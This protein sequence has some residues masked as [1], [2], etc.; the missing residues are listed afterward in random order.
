MHWGLDFGTTNTR[1]AR[2][3]S[4][5]GAPRALSLP[6]ASRRPEGGDET[7]AASA[8][9]TMVRLREDPDLWARLSARPWLRGRVSWGSWGSIG[10]AAEEAGQAPALATSLKP[11]LA[12]SALQTVARVNG[13]AVSAREATRAFLRELL[14][15]VRELSGS[16]VDAL[17]L[18]AP[19]D[20]YEDYRAEL[21]SLCAELGVRRTRHV[22]EP[23]AAALGYGLSLSASRRVLV[24]D[25][26]GGTLD[27]AHVELD[28][29]AAERG[30]CRVLGKA[31]RALGGTDVDRWLLEDVL[32]RADVQLTL[33][34]AGGAG[35]WRRALLDEARRL[36]ES[37]YFQEEGM[38]LAPAGGPGQRDEVSYRREDLV[39][40][41]EARGLPRQLDEALDEALAAS[42]GDA[43]VE[44]ALLVGGSTLL[45]GVYAG[46]QRRFG[47]DRVRAW[48]PFEAVALGAAA[49]CAD[50]VRP[51]DFIVHDYAVRLHDA[52][53]R[54]YHEIVVPRGTRFPTP[55]DLWRRQ[56]VPVCPLGEPERV[57]KLVICEL[58]SVAGQDR[59]LGFD[60]AERA[61]RV[62]GDRLIVPLN[63]RDP[64]MGRL[65]PPQQPTDA[66]ARLDVALGV[67]ADRWLCA[68]VRDLRT[69]REL[70]RGHP[71]VRL[72]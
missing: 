14:V 61:R 44:D 19:V 28:A 70:M 13:R 40:L 54:P 4:T 59:A 66:A 41:L 45:P 25:F 8:I 65:D 12:R 39:T 43:A 71:V 55:E 62:E 15:Q 20:A 35:F 31:G 16:R 36:K 60:Q 5:A 26:G 38:F 32:A 9:P 17:A 53:G 49:L 57:F 6:R 30:A 56:V 72:L 63:E 48:Q 52:A 22:D 23:V 68:T 2:W 3:D 37:L 10:R 64:A 7:F 51:A 34:E 46:L 33:D 11:T 1:V 18:T 27:I 42:G 47:R 21:A 58:G 50:A 24:V 29:G 67:N 69:E